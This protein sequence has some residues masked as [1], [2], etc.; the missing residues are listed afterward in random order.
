VIV[1][2]FSNNLNLQTIMLSV[3]DISSRI[4]SSHYFVL[5]FGIVC[6]HSDTFFSMAKVWS[7]SE[8][9]S[10]GWLIAPISIWII[11]NARKSRMS[12]SLSPNPFTGLFLLA[13]ANAAWLV[14]DVAKVSV[15]KGFAVVAMIPISVYLVLGSA[16]FKSYIFALLFLFAM[17]P[18][19]EGLT[20]VLMEYTADATVWAIS[21]SGIPIYREGM[22]FTLPTGQW[23]V[24]EACSGLRYLI[25]AAVLAVLFCYLNYSTWPRRIVF[26]FTTVALSIV[27][28]W[29]RA[30]LIV[31]LGHFSEMK[32]GAGDDHVWYGWLFFGL[33]MAVTFWIGVKFGDRSQ[34]EFTEQ[35]SEFK[36][37]IARVDSKVVLRR[38]W[39]SSAAG[40]L[41]VAVVIPLSAQFDTK[42]RF[43]NLERTLRH[44]DYEVSQFGFAFSP[45]YLNPI[46][47]LQ[48]SDQNLNSIFAAYYAEQ[49]SS[50]D[51]LAWNHRLL[52]ENGDARLVS[53]AS[54]VNVSFL[55]VGTLDEYRV[56]S[57]GKEFLVWQWFT[58]G[59]YSVGHPYLAKIVRVVSAFT[60]FGD[61]SL[62]VAVAVPIFDN[63][64][65]AQRETLK[66]IATAVSKQ[67]VMFTSQRSIAN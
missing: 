55:S 67:A 56:R 24:V 25:A 43:E 39:L 37:G 11:W 63:N 47:S 16:Y 49:K 66:D 59:P 20:P 12:L 41:L 17:V 40:V 34:G 2:F 8:N 46:A 60:G 53:E 1:K 64:L 30:Y 48:Q 42:V 35:R 57:K 52:P 18:A 29:V 21:V 31:L 7:V 19:G 23:S 13:L 62:V 28:N 38:A 15:V 50:V 65:D 45:G 27:A 22:F 44:K 10:H 5:I 4:N 61:H 36:T 32:Y 33:V 58:V 26:F 6:F 14:G 9:Y 54:K 3:K 51:M